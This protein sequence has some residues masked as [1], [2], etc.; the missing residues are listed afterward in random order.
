[1][2]NV[3]PYV[4]DPGSTRPAPKLDAG[5]LWTGGVATAA[6][7]ALVAVAG[8]LIA[9]GLFDVPVLAP[10]GEGT[11]GD[12]STARLAAWPRSR[13]CWP[14]ACCTCCWCPRPARAGSSPGSSGWPP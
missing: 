12:A 7:A 6:V 10:T 3:P 9:R 1:M 2:S 5:R 8:V 14:P 4:S 13:P 11:L